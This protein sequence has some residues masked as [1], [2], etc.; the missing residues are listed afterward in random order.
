[1]NKELKRLQY[2]AEVIANEY[3]I[4]GTV[5]AVET[6]PYRITEGAMSSPY[7]VGIGPL[8]V[9]GDTVDQTIESA[10]LKAEEYA[11]QQKKRMT[12]EEIYLKA[13]A[14]ITKAETL[15]DAHVL[16]CKAI[17]QVADKS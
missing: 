16:A 2:A 17:R 3:G 6:V 10:R 4:E 1:M 13:L 9:L 15:T 12:A 5:R 14:D 7:T 8:M 11:Q